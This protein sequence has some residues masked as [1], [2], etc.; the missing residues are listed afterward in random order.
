M[1]AHVSI[2]RAA[3][4]Y[5]GPLRAIVHAHKYGGHRSV[6]RRLGARMAGAG[7]D[8]LQGADVLV[9]IPLHRRKAF[10]RT[11]NQADDLARHVPLRRAALLTRTRATAPQAGLGAGAR[12]SNL[13]GAFGPSVRLR[14][15]CWAARRASGGG[16]GALPRAACTWLARRWSVQH[17]VVVI[18]DDVRTTGAT[19]DEAAATLRAWGAREVRALTAALVAHERGGRPDPPPRPGTAL[20]R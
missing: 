17:A 9:P 18:V 7:V 11:F 20:H 10:S 6:A 5:E 8:V 12:A 3:G 16:G 4:R 15:G 19:L 1:P 14:I 13:R 2:A